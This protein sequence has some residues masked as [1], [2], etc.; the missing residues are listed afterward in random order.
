[1]QPASRALVIGA[2]YWIAGS[3]QEGRGQAY[4]ETSAP[5]PGTRRRNACVAANLEDSDETRRGRD[6][7]PRRNWGSSETGRLGSNL[8]GEPPTGTCAELAPRSF[9]DWPL[10]WRRYSD[11]G[12]TLR[13]FILVSPLC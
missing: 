2:P 5:H 12:A 11:V 13:R 6:A 9:G 7:S 4:T 1:M 3:L 10:G 8:R